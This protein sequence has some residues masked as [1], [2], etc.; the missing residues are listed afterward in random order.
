MC[1]LP[2]SCES[3]EHEPG[4]IIASVAPRAAK[5][6]SV[7][8]FPGRKKAIQT[9]NPTTSA[10]ANGVHNPIMMKIARTVP[11]PADVGAAIVVALSKNAFA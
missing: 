7:A 3:I 5:R 4:P 1:F 2:K 6:I 8:G 9:S 10:P 11:T